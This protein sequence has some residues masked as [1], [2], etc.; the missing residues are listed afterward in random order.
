MY[1]PGPGQRFFFTLKSAAQPSAQLLQKQPGGS[2]HRSFTHRRWGGGTGRPRAFCA[3][4]R[5]GCCPEWK[6][7][8]GASRVLSDYSN[9]GE[10]TAR[11]GGW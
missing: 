10:E 7:V 1:L 6:D 3:R 2:G 11:F 4:I 9:I 8:T 5:V